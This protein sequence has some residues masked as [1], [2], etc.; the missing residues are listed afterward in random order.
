MSDV[1]E[2]A[3]SVVFRYINQWFTS[4][5]ERPSMISDISCS[6]LAMV[7]DR[8]VPLWPTLKTGRMKHGQRKSFSVPGFVVPVPFNSA[9]PSKL[10]DQS[11]TLFLLPQKAFEAVVTAIGK[12]PPGLFMSSRALNFYGLETLPATIATYP[13]LSKQ[14][15]KQR[16]LKLDGLMSMNRTTDLS[17]AT[18]MRGT[19]KTNLRKNHKLPELTRRSKLVMQRAEK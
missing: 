16:S 13:G 7:A 5:S 8:P 4:C 15:S 9:F 14:S 18:F 10:P 2:K 1:W 12:I 17:P 11:P 19:R 3:L 6:L